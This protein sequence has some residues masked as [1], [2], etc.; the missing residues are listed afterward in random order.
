MVLSATPL[1][2]VNSQGS[3]RNDLLG[4]GKMAQWVKTI[5]A[6]PDNRLSS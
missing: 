1:Y 4:V 6:K 5:A 2:P 3:F